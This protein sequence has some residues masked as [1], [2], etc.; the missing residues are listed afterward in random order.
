MRGARKNAV[1]GIG[2][3]NYSEA[4]SRFPRQRLNFRATIDAGQRDGGKPVET[5]L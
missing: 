5:G 3:D 4:G 1:R 2:V